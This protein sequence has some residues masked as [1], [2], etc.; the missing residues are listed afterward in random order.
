MS[1]ILTLDDPC[2]R[3]ATLTG[4]KMSA[5]AAL[6]QAGLPVPDG[7]VL[8]AR[9]GPVS[10]PAVSEQV[11]AAYEQLVR[12]APGTVAVRSSAV[13]EDAARRS[14]AGLYR[15][16]LDVLGGPALLRAVEDCQDSAQQPC[17]Q[18]YD[19][20]AGP[21][22][23]AVGVMKM[24]MPALSGVLFTRSPLG[25]SQMMLE[26]VRGSL[27][28]LVSGRTIP[29]HLELA[30]DMTVVARVPGEH[31]SGLLD[32]ATT[33]LVC[34]LGLRAAEVLG[35]EVDVEWGWC[36]ERAWLLQARPVTGPTGPPGVL[37]S[38]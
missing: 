24:V 14:A 19:P 18:A 20:V 8:T 33:E 10:R 32:A 26:V 27:A 5:L 25:S 2:C 17:V 34:A 4:G 36:D 29:E 23:V 11:L 38:R 30:G 16:T 7:F 12:H 28:P 37:A 6:R 15:T 3:D 9:A 1:V 13:R 31:G 22:D 35:W 21:G